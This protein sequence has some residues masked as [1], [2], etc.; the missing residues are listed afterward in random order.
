MVNGDVTALNQLMH[1]AGGRGA[2]RASSD[3]MAY[4]LRVEAPGEAYHVNGNAVDG[5]KLFRDDDDR[6]FFLRLLA[7]E[8]E[9]SEW[10]C[11]AYSLMSTHYHLLVRLRKPTLSSGFQHLHA[12]Y[13]RGYNLK[14]GRRGTLW[15]RRFHDVLIESEPQLLE[16][17][18]YI[19][20]N[21][22]RANMCDDPE[23]HVWCS[24]GAAIGESSPD[25]L[26]D[27]RD[28]L[29]PFGRRQKEARLRLRA[30][31]EESDRRKRRSQ[32]SLRDVSEA[33]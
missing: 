33:A 12:V 29:V 20:L 26:V 25:P 9:R 31:V 3:A 2:W 6:E 5:C 15:R 18:R 10:S 32:R 8:I 7:K 14:W 11:I 23:D 17:I 28:L 22:P 27:E 24:Y 1:P 4:P 30:F 13:A 19:A 16:T 21:A